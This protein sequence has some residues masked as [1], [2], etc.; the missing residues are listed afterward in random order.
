[1]RLFTP[2]FFPLS[3]S[4][5]TRVIKF[6]MRSSRLSFCHICSQR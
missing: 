5:S 4:S 6:W 3:S 1:M 2:V